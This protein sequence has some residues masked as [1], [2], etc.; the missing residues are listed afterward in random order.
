MALQNVE[1]DEFLLHDA[2]RGRVLSS[3]VVGAFHQQ[4][5]EG[6]GNSRRVLF[7]SRQY[8]DQDKVG[9]AFDDKLRVRVRARASSLDGSKCANHM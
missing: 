6:G 3:K 1:A 8:F 4:P 5:A 7:V 9:Q 2:T